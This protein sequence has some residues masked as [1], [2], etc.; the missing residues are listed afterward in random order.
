MLEFWDE[1]RYGFSF[2]SFKVLQE[3]EAVLNNV[4]SHEVITNVAL[5]KEFNIEVQT[6]EEVEFEEVFDISMLLSSIVTIEFNHT[7]M[8]RRLL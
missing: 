7:Q 3:Q 8:K 5:I 2:K 6:K 4:A 1:M